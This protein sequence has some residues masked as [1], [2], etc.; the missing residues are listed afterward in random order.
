M[1]N[2]YKISHTILFVVSIVCLTASKNHC[3]DYVLGVDYFC[4]PLL[5]K[6]N[7][8]LSARIGLITN[9]TGV[10]SSG[11]R[12]VDN[13]RKKGFNVTML[14]AP[15]HG[16]SGTEKAAKTIHNSHD[17]ASQLPII[18]LYEQGRKK[19]S[20]S[21]VHQIDVFVFDIQDVGM[22][23]YTYS[24][25]LL[26]ALEIALHHKKPLVVLDRPNPLAAR[27]EGPVA[28]KIKDSFLASIPLPLRHGLTM[29]EIARFCNN[30]V[31]EKPAQLFVVPLKQYQRTAA[32]QKGAFV[33]LSP[34]IQSLSSV[35]G[36]SFLGLLGEI[37]PFDVGVGTKKAF[38]KIG[39]PKKY[40]S[41][42]D[43]QELAKQLQAHGVSST[44]LNEYVRNKEKY[45]GIEIS[46]NNCNSCSAFSCLLSCI[47]LCK[48]QSV[49]ITF[50]TYFDR[51]AGTD[52]IQ[53]YYHDHITRDQL[54]EN[55]K[56][57]L[58]SLYKQ[59][60]KIFIYE[61]R[62]TMVSVF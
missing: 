61:P 42:A 50:S 9:Q 5:S 24:A 30:F 13:L 52:I 25:T 12:T 23:H 34:N 8:P 44:R 59:A 45:W 11:A 21:L 32:Y 43:W 6:M 62:P 38:Q 41:K 51:A 46:I 4:L 36:Y 3:Q 1:H 17:N 29:G 22:R 2:G 10:D 31:L 14:F 47:E 15:E 54:Q 20:S 53:K 7:L 60:E 39:L 56:K 28:Q 19:I 37:K 27:M 33:P 57:D 49:P 18:S 55:I 16:I 26:H 35:Y 40:F 58:E 48:K